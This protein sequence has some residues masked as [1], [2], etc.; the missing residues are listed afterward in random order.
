MNRNA[1]NSIF[2]VKNV[3]SYALFSGRFLN[4]AK[5][6]GV[7]DLTN[8]MFLYESPIAMHWVVFC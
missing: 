6:A 5:S 7:K 4:F 1:K 2:S 8:I 3:V